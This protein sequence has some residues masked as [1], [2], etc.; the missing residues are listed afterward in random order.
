MR[1]HTS[2]KDSTWDEESVLKI[3]PE[4]NRLLRYDLL[5]EVTGEGVWDYDVLTNLSEYN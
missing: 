3:S 2:D 4:S 1:K 5:S